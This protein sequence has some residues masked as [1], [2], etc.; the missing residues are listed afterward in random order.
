L[1]TT[2]VDTPV[3]TEVAITETFGTDAPLESVT[4]PKMTLLAVWANVIETTAISAQQIERRKIIGHLS[5][6]PGA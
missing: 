3:V 6:N 5:N 4:E 2:L 1:A